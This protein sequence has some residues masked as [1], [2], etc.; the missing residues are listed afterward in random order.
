MQQQ[1]TM[2]RTLADLGLDDTVLITR[3]GRFVGGPTRGRLA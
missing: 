1:P 3:D 2:C